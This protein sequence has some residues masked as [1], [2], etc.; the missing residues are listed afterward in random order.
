MV[1]LKKLCHSKIK[2]NLLGSNIL[3]DEEHKKRI[4]DD[5]RQKISS[6]RWRDSFCRKWR[7]QNIFVHW[8]EMKNIVCLMMGNCCL[9]YVF[10][11]IMQTFRAVSLKI[12]K[13]EFLS[14]LF[15]FQKTENFRKN[16]NW[17]VRKAEKSHLRYY[18]N[19]VLFQ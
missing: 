15:F 3:I 6:W 8:N 16:W 2:K 17:S 4:R 13:Y 18:K 9:W 1:V 7:K 11:A 10:S 12:E 5:V 19:N 14:L